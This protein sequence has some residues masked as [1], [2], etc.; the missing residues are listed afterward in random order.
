MDLA[1][2]LINLPYH[3]VAVGR[4]NEEVPEIGFDRKKFSD[5][6]WQDAVLRFMKESEMIIWRPDTSHGL[7]WELSKIFELNYRNKLVVWTEMGY[8]NLIDV[9]KT[10]YDIFARKANQQFEEIFPPFNRYKQF[11]V[12]KEKD[13]WEAFMFI[14]HTPLFNKISGEK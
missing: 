12:S 14:Q 2:Q 7:F 10:R 4:P 9:Q 5:D 1:E 6:K 13:H 11:I 3:L 8:E